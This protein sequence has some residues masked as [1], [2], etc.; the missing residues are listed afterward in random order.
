MPCTFSCTFYLYRVKTQ[1]LLKIL[2]YTARLARLLYT[3][4][5]SELCPPPVETACA[6]VWA[7]CPPGVVNEFN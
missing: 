6:N 2:L 4:K 1:M 7:D 3:M 5:H